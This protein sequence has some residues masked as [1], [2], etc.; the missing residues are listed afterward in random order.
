MTFSASSKWC[1][2]FWCCLLLAGCRNTE[3]AEPSTGP[4]SGRVVRLADG[5]TFTLLVAGNKQLKVRLH[6]IDAPERQQD[7]GNAARK[8]MQELT[9]GHTIHIEVKDTDRYGRTVGIARRDDGLIINEEMLRTGMAWH[10][11]AYDKNPKWS[12]LQQQARNKKRGLW[13]QPNPTPPWEWRKIKRA[14]TTKPA[15]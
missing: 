4:N 9:T 11:T 13:A 12:Q 14:Q 10:Y 5:D 8:K 1:W 3:N 7:F 2:V 15:A 6:G